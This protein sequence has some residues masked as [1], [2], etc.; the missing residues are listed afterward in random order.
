MTD[1]RLATLL[2]DESR[3]LPI[4]HRVA[5]VI[6]MRFASA[7]R[8]DLLQEARIRLWKGQGNYRPEAGAPEAWV[9]TVA[10]R[11]MIDGLRTWTWVNGRKAKRL[12]GA[13]LPVPMMGHIED[14]PD[15]TAAGLAQPAEREPT[16]DAIDETNRVLARL[17]PRERFVFTRYHRDSRTMA[18]IGQKL[19]LSESRICQIH[20]SA[21]QRVREITMGRA[22][23]ERDEAIRAAM[24]AGESATA[25]S[26]RFGISKPRLYQIA[27]RP[28][29]GRPP[30]HA[31]P[32][33]PPPAA[34]AEPDRENFSAT[35]GDALAEIRRKRKDLA[36]L[37]AG[38]LKAEDALTALLGTS[39]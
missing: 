23:P 8:D 33:S 38:L 17:S 4:L 27:P 1:P 3:L 11:A 6:P 14:L 19:G 36:D 13:G 18:Q 7:D 37:D 24:A 12:L 16:A 15:G 30:A 21:L 9:S 20:Q 10:R 32:P 22:N 29:D 25:V 35:L 26:E 31:E 28:K 2:A 5:R 34:N 39:A